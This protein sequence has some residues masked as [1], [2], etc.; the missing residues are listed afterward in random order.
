MD[1]IDLAEDRYW[2]MGFDKILVNS[3]VIVQLTASEEGLSSMELV[4][5]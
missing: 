5:Y 3:W 2:T 4:T 1:W